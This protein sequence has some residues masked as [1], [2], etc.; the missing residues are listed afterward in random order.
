MRSRRGVFQIETAICIFETGTTKT[1]IVRQA[2]FRLVWDPVESSTES[3]YREICSA[4]AVTANDREEAPR[5][6][7]KGWPLPRSRL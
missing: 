5:E 3:Y 2:A 1:R 6:K 4:S 7:D